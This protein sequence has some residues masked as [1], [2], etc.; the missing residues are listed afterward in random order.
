MNF[1][2]KVFI[3]GNENAFEC[4]Y[5]PDDH[6]I[7]DVRVNDAEFDID[8]LFV[9]TGRFP[10]VVT[11]SLREALTSKCDLAY[12]ENREEYKEQLHA[13]YAETYAEG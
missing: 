6:Y 9:S 13:G 12:A 11:V 1:S 10:D 8:G 2:L 5:C 7:D 4:E 3:D